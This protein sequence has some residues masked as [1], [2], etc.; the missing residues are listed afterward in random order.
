MAKFQFLYETDSETD[1]GYR[2]VEAENR[3]AARLEWVRQVTAEGQKVRLDAIQ[4]M[5]AGA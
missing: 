2:V 5:K 4:G 1:D 3:E